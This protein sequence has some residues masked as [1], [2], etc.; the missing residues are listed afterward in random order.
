MSM[1]EQQINAMLGAVCI[2]HRPDS[3]GFEKHARIDRI[4]PQLPFPIHIA[5]AWGGAW[6][7]PIEIEPSRLA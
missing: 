4:E 6:C 7:L 1:S 5:G 2:F 3:A